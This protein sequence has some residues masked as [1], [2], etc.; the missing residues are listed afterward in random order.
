MTDTPISE[1]VLVV[2]SNGY[3]RIEDIR[4]CLEV[5]EE[6]SSDCYRSKV[7]LIRVEVL[8]K[9]KGLCYQR[10]NILYSQNSQR[11]REMS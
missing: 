5:W 6:M 7:A 8:V 1:E 3:C 2:M 4:A 9:K 11:L 10:T